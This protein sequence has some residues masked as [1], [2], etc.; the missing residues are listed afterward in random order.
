MTAPADPSRR[1]LIAGLALL[2]ALPAGMARAA[3][4]EMR[5]VKDPNCG[6]CAD[7]VEIVRAAGFSVTVEE[8]DPAALQDH[9]AASG[10]TAAMASCHTAHVEGYVIEGHVPVADIRRLLDERP[11][12]IGLSVPG[13]PFGSPGMGP[14]DQREAYSVHLIARDGST[15]VFATYAAA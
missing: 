2:W 3:A 8:R 15:T 13:M 11:D 6:C 10:I 9:K 5:V 4:T 14:E 12:A 7:W 1:R